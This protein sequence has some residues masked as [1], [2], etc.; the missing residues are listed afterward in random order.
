MNKR[1]L[2]RALVAALLCAALLCPAL[3]LAEEETL[4]IEDTVGAPLDMDL[5]AA[6]DGA[7]PEL[8]DLDLAGDL[9][10]NDVPAP[11]EDGP[12]DLGG[13][14]LSNEGDDGQSQQTP[15]PEDVVTLV[16]SYTGDPL[17]KVYDCNKYGAYKKKNDDGTEEIVYVIE[18]LKTVKEKFSLTPVKGQS[19]VEGHGNVSFRLS[20]S[21]QYDAADV[22]KYA[23]EFTLTLT[24]DDAAWYTLQNPVVK[25]TAAITPRE[26][27]VS[28][29]ANLGKTYGED[30]PVY[31]SGTSFTL[32]Y[33]SG[34]VAVSQDVSG[35]PTYGVPTFTSDQLEA[36]KYLIMESKLKERDFFPGFLG[37]KAGEK[38]GRYR[39]T[40]GTLD[41][42][43]N[44]K[45]KVAEGYFTVNRRDISD[46]DVTVKSVSDRIYTG[47]AIKPRPAVRYKGRKLK[48][49]TDYRLKYSRVKTLGT[50][51]V[52][53]VGKGNFTGER[54]LTFRIV[55]K[56][57][58]LS[59]LTPGKGQITA[60]WK[61]GKLNAGY[62]LAYGADPD[63]FD[64]QTVTVKGINS[65]RVTLKDLS[66]NTTYYVRVRT[67]R[68][69]GGTTYY[70]GWSKA[71][72][73][74]TK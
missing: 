73:T 69:V 72:N 59:K 57:T 31:P 54:K 45:L 29:R 21:K 27:T 19:M 43:G 33:T 32:K 35:V 65:T 61:K 13:D 26:V 8:P 38:A 55:L 40:R 15:D 58:A 71:K 51:T 9:T 2:W 14:V 3:A 34:D 44:F 30:D 24:G 37:R 12:V 48:L 17:T 28:P 23:F 60:V 49:N 64:A 16:A 36:V 20:L 74:R 6:F 56:P 10:V 7:L 67:Y 5:D 22:G 53:V 11:G 47:K 66:S 70:S 50:A 18:A 25:V 63:F 62:E 1:K 41:F 46:D 39:V 4:L 52:T 42:G 68:K